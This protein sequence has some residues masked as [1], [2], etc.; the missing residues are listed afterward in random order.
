MSICCLRARVVYSFMMIG[1]GKVGCHSHS[2]HDHNLYFV[3]CVGEK[4]TAA[5]V[6][7]DLLILSSFLRQVKSAPLLSFDAFCQFAFQGELT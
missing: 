4:E 6:K 2:D 5:G 3:V 7:K 1:F